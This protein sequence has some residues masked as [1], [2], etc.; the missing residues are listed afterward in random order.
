MTRKRS[1]C[2]EET[3]RKIGDANRGRRASKA[4]REKMSLAKLGKP[5]W[6]KGKKL[7]EQE[8]SKNPNW[9]GG[10]HSEKKGY[11]F[12]L[13]KGHPH[14]KFGGYVYEHRLV[15]EKHLGRYLKPSE[16]VHHINGNKKDNRIE[17]LQLFKSN[18]DHANHHRKIKRG[19]V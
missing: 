11:V 3:K 12:V 7:P 9:K 18:R 17:N 19:N 5:S 8:G 1:P 2:S 13:A 16:V 10:R 14:P 6:N 4:A 15:M